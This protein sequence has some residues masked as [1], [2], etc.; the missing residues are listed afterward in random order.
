MSFQVKTI[1]R[2]RH[3]PKPTTRGA[4][5][6]SAMVE[7]EPLRLMQSAPRRVRS[8]FSRL[9][10]RDCSPAY[11]TPGCGAA[12]PW[13]DAGVAV[14][15]ISR[16]SSGRARLQPLFVARF[17]LAAPGVSQAIRRFS[18]LASQHMNVTFRPRGQSGMPSMTGVR[19]ADSVASRC[20]I[21]P[22]QRLCL[23]FQVD[24]TIDVRGV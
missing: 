7:A 21:D 19:I 18:W 3:D 15:G 8:A 13:R 23:H 10:I 1:Q 6:S 2:R 17:M 16:R 22:S 12:P 11:T 9:S 14:A 5:I 20:C 24:L 4:W